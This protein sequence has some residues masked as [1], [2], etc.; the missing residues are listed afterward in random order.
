MVRSTRNLAL[1]VFGVLLT[2]AGVADSAADARAQGRLVLDRVFYVNDKDKMPVAWSVNGNTYEIQFSRRYGSDSCIGNYRV[3]FIFDRDIRTLDYGE[4]FRVG[5]RK[6]HGTPPCGHKWTTATVRDANNTSGPGDKFVRNS[7]RFP[8]NYEYNGNILT[9]QEGRVNM[10][11]GPA[12][13]TYVL[14]A[15]LKKPAPYT[16]FSLTA[17]ENAL[18]F[19]YRHEAAAGTARGN[20]WE[21]GIDRPGSDYR[22]FDLARPD[23]ALCEAACANDNRCKA[24]TWVR[25]G[26][27]GSNARCWLKYRVP[28]AQASNCCVSGTRVLIKR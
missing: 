25:P 15:E 7:P 9:V 28:A 27:Q 26:H 14:K 18:H 4:T 1:L 5:I 12:E 24:W 10:W 21:R 2:I 13:A 11:G 23:P 8:S 22:N 17:G 6:I 16:M 19:I 3:R 20:R